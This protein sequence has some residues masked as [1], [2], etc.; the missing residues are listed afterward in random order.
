RE[1]LRRAAPA[2]R[3]RLRRVR[4][5]VERGGAPRPRERPG[6]RASAAHPA[7]RPLRDPDRMERRPLDRHLSLPA[8]A[9]ALRVRGLRRADR[10]GAVILDP[11][12]FRDPARTASGEPRASVRLAALETL[13]LN[14]GTLCNIECGHCYIE[15]SPRNDRLAYLRL[16]DA[17]PLLDEVR[18][19][20]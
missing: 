7:R 4:G 20:G 15:S 13:W 17:L 18:A 1:S 3:V 16:A 19:A 10:G 9:R 12:K 5:R 11:A 2:P 8:P 6:R 14:T